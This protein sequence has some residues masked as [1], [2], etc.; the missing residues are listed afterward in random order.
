MK[1]PVTSIGSICV[2][3][4]QRDPGLSPDATFRYIDI[5]S[6]DKDAK[7]ILAATEIRGADAPSRARKEVRGGDVLVSTVRPNLNAVAI[8]PDELDRQI[9]STGFCV[10][11]ANRQVADGRYIFYRCL[12][13]EFVSF[14]VSQMRGANYPAVSDGVVRRADIPF[15]SLREQQ[16]IV[17]LL[18]QA[19]R[20]RRQRV[21]ADELADR[22]LPALFCHVFGEPATNPKRWPTS[23]LQE[24][25]DFISG[26]T[27]SKEIAAFWDGTIPWV[28][29]KDM[30]R[31]EL[32]DAIDHVSERALVATNL[33]LIEANTV[34]IVVRGMILAHTVPVCLARVPVTINQDMKAL[35]AKGDATAE[36]L[37]WALLTQHHRL[38]RLVTTAAHGTKK[39][40]TEALAALEIPVPPRDRRDL[41]R[42]WTTI[43]RDQELAADQRRNCGASLEQVWQVM[44]HRAFNGE[45][46]A[47]WREAHLKELLAEMEQQAKVLRAAIDQN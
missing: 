10:L 11:R 44:L 25:A 1:W 6:V 9:A 34:L 19:D 21:E 28:S 40:D 46:T 20:V 27:P 29:P 5:A 14:L 12:T 45:L 47:K 39:L 3:T 4:G 22:I 26:A 2:P 41:M 30:K 42:K 16:R 43:V 24:L 7:R 33:K 13:P 37:Q 18:E 8:V 32:H 31:R 23:P 36:F 38:L 17:E 35:G 15:P